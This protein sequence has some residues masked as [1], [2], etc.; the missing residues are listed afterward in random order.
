M[1]PLMELGIA[2]KPRKTNWD[3][4]PLFHKYNAHFRKSGVT[5]ELAENVA[6]LQYGDIPSDILGLGKSVLLDAL[7]CILSGSTQESSRKVLRYVRSQECTPEATVAVYGYKTH[8]YYAALLN[9][10]FCHAWAFDDSL[11]PSLSGEGAV[12]PVV[13]A[14]AERNLANGHEVL[15]ALVTG[16]EVICRIAAAAPSVPL[17]RPLDPVSTF[18][19]WGAAAAVGKILRLDAD[20]MENAFTLTSAQAAATLQAEETGGEAIRLHAGFAAMHGLRVVQLARLGL[21]GAREILEGPE[22]FLMCIAGVNPDGSPK[23]DATKVNESFGKDW[24]LRGVTLKKY[25]VESSQLSIIEN[26]ARM[27]DEK[28]IRQEEVEEIQIRTD[29]ISGES[30]SSAK[31]PTA[32]DLHATQYSMTWG[33]SMAMTLGK[34]DIASYRD[35]IPPSGRSAEIAEFAKKVRILNHKATERER[36]PIQT[37]TIRLKNDTTWSIDAAWPRGNCLHNPMTWEE[38][39]QKFRVQAQLGGISSTQQDRIIDITRSLEEQDDVTALIH[40]LVR[41]EE[42]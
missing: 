3:F 21:S 18:G 17:R 38:L 7:G 20:D 5:R 6:N 11:G 2:G 40:N 30:L 12:V 26:L 9:G 13:L 8:A 19:P 28:R 35:N 29:P 33:A 27:R 36:T 15:T 16:L 32:N 1:A 39:E 23:F 31:L 37:I 14:S 41:R 10:A 42:Q 22:G 25:P 24:L 34:N 4:E